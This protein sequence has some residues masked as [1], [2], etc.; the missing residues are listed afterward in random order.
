M[1]SIEKWLERLGL[2]QYGSAFLQADIDPSVLPDLSEA[3][4]ERLGVSLGHRKKLLRAIAALSEEAANDAVSPPVGTTA[5]PDAERRQ[6]TVMFCDLVGSTALSSRLDPED[7]RA[8]IAAY[9]RQATEVVRASGGFVAQYMGDGVLAYF[10]YPQA[11]EDDAERAVHAA[12]GLVDAIAHLPLT[13]ALFQGERDDGRSPSHRELAESRL[14]ARVGI[15]TGLVVV[16]DVSDEGAAQEQAVIGE[17][18]N[19]AARLQA[20]A[21]PNTV[22]VAASTRRLLGG[23]FEYRDLGT[24]ALKGFAEPVPAFQVLRPSAVESRFEARQERGAVPL[25]GREE[26]LELLLRRWRQARAGESRVVLLT[27]EP[28]IGKSRI[29]RE[30]QDRVTRDPHL[31]LRYFC[32]PQHQDSA[33]YPF[34]SQLQQASGFSREDSTEEK[35]AKLEAVLAHSNATEEEVEL[36]AALLSLRVGE[37]FPDMDMQRNKEKTLQALLVQLERLA[38]MRPVLVVFEDAHW[39]DP[40]SLELVSLIVAQTSAPMLLLITARPEFV[41]PWPSHAHVTTITLTRLGRR[42]AEGLV[43]RVAGG[44]PLPRDVLEQIL[45]HTDGVPLFVEELTKTVLEGSLLRAEA[46][47]YV[48][49]G[50]LP[51]LAIPTTLHDSLM[52]RLDRLAP[53]REVVQIGAALGHDFSYELL[54]AVAG[55]PD[56]RL[57]DALSQLVHSELVFCRGTPP[58]SV[59]TFKHALVQ[60]AA[61]ATMLR[62]RRQQLHARIATIL[63][64]QFPETAATRL[65]L[66][67][68]HCTEAGLTEKAVAYWTKAGQHAVMRSG[69]REAETLLRKGLVLLGG[70]PDTDQRGDR[71]LEVQIALGQALAATRGYGGL[72]VREAYGR[73]RELCDQHDRPDKLLSVLLGQWHYHAH[74]NEARSMRQ[75][76]ADLRRLGE[77]QDDNVTRYIGCWASWWP[78]LVLGDFVGAEIYFKEGFALY[79]SAKEPSYSALSPTI[80]AFVTLLTDSAFALVCCGKIDQGLSRRDTAVTE[81][82]GRSRAFPLAHA[83]WWACQLSWCARLRPEVLLAYADELQAV[84]AD[85]GLS[86]NAQAQ[87]V[88]GWCLVALGRPDEGIPLLASG[89]ASFGT[90]ANTLFTPMLLTMMADAKRMAGQID[91]GLAHVAEALNLADATDEKWGQAE[92]LRLR[93]D[94]LN[95]SGDSVAAE[96]SFRDAIALAQRQGAKLFELRACASLA[97]LWRDQGK[98]AEARHLLAPVYAWFTEGFE[99]P[100]LVEARGLLEELSGSSH[101]LD[102][103]SVG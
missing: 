54:R 99:A 20:L 33:L 92:M 53:F 55:L 97:R 6:V 38:A 50:P 23:F 95:V 78:C 26:E 10:G 27:G 39:I 48:L 14:Q 16:G 15:A 7:L 18:P 49:T 69:M 1:Q 73:A 37:H 4:L 56:A 28:G 5:A 8:V 81:A 19:L 36:V 82:R 59:Y 101:T 75:L 51:P 24:T 29:V 62:S 12:L 74:N 90:G 13:A 45:A 66:L 40:T 42:E 103:R 83:L 65:D 2:R 63:E 47:C 58:N 34:V 89:L 21:E 46:D 52:A 72:A 71:E 76:A 85:R 32:S 98:R 88:R 61:Y 11:H 9:H 57:R 80:D 35:L 67:A 30:L 100:D 86:Y 41:P 3:D 91:A 68:H 31:R 102:L 70:L 77:T 60:D 44:K 93:G 84:S 64:S 96:A 79:D 22:V 87:A 17:T 94:L 43:D 25:V